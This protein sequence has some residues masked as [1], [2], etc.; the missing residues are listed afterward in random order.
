VAACVARQWATAG[1]LALLAGGLLGFLVYNFPWRAGQRA[2]IF[3]GDGG[4]LPVGFLLSALAIQITFTSP[5]DPGYALGTHWYGALAPVVILAV[6]IYDSVVVTLLRLSQGK[7]PMVGDHQH[8]SHRMVMRGFTQRGAVLLI[9]AFGVVCSTGGL[10]LGT[11][12][13]WQAAL[14]ALQT[15]IVMVA[16]AALERPMLARM[17]A[18]ERP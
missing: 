3:L 8:F 16:I 17:R 18:G 1:V 5:G 4:T 15:G 14:V 12:E 10:L 9:C 7:S 2:R 13:P 11:A 6:P